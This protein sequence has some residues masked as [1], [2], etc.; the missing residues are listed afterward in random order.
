MG[1]KKVLLLL[2]IWYLVLQRKMMEIDWGE[3]RQIW[4]RSSWLHFQIWLL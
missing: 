1:G 2:E 3:C 4:T